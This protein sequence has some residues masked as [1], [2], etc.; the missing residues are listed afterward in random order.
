MWY[1]GMN[2]LIILILLVVAYRLTRHWTEENTTGTLRQKIVN[3]VN[4]T[5][6]GLKR[7]GPLCIDYP[8]MPMCDRVPQCPP[9]E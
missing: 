9:S 8:D 5:C 6:I 7:H 3:F 4:R 1:K 2:V